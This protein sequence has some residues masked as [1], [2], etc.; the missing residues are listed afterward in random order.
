MQVL[1]VSV[2]H[3]ADGVQLAA[4]RAPGAV[5]EARVRPPIAAAFFRSARRSPS[6]SLTKGASSSRARPCDRSL[7]HSPAAMPPSTFR[8]VE[9]AEYYFT[10]RSYLDTMY[11]QGHDVFDAL[12]SV[13]QGTPMQPAS[14]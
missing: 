5:M 13:F 14:G 6:T 12:L 7:H 4:C 1:L 11:K 2:T 3:T 10:I 9:G 8:S